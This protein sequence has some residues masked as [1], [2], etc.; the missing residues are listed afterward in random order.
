MKS[1]NIIAKTARLETASELL[2]A[3]MGRVAKKIIEIEKTGC[4]DDGY[5]L[6]LE[7][8]LDGLEMEKRSLS[9]DNDARTLSVI[10]KYGAKEHG[11]CFG[12]AFN[13]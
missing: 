7:N 9:I 1:N 4:V 12:V 11:C 8:Q 5:L 3:E 13:P 10:K 2:S 6:G